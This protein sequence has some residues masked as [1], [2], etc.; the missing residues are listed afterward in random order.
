MVT[1]RP[2]RLDDVE[3]LVAI[4]GEPSVRRWW[5]EPPPHAQLEDQLFGRSDEPLLVIDV[6]GEVA[7]GI[8]YYEEPEPDYRSA[9]IDIFLGAQWQGRG[10]GT[11]AIRLLARFLFD[12]RGHH[13]LTIDPAVRN[14]HAIAAYKKVG[15]QP[16]GIMRQ[17]ERQP[18]GRWHDGLLMDLLRNELSRD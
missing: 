1:V 16:V 5:R 6:Q 15:F 7:G 11:E 2:G 9:S 4:L 8:Q 17:Y 12:E 10:I 18:D 3:L 13:R 14:V